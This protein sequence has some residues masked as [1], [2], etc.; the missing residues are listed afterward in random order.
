MNNAGDGC[1][2]VLLR[3]GLWEELVGSAEGAKRLL[4]MQLLGPAVGMLPE[5]ARLSQSAF[6]TTI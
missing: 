1:L 6:R 4:L 5:Y 3:W 2:V